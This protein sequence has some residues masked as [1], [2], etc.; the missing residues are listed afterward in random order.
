MD[1]Q[2]VYIGLVHMSLYRLP[3]IICIKAQVAS[4]TKKY[5]HVHLNRMYIYIYAYDT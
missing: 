2:R 3:R 1:L 5:L 4:I